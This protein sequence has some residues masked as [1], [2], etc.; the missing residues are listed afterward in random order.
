MQTKNRKSRFFLILEIATVAVAL[1]IYIA[2]FRP[3]EK[4][5]AKWNQYTER[6]QLALDKSNFSDARANFRLALELSEQ[7]RREPLDVAGVQDRLADAER[8][9]ENYG[10]A[11]SLDERAQPIFEKYQTRWEGRYADFLAKLAGTYRQVE[12]YGEAE[13]RYKQ[14][15]LLQEKIFGSEALQ[16]VPTLN[17][18]VSFYDDRNRDEIAEPLAKRSIAICKS[19]LGPKD[20]CTAYGL[21]MLS[22]VYDG[23]GKFAEAEALADE[24]LPI[25]VPCP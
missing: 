23:E 22:L 20:A 2:I 13:G 18:M 15:L 1:L 17:A 6:G 21:S 12:R 24:A 11:L 8:G 14:A 25:L 4:V 16:L 10:E 5:E 19:H 7:H 3:K 9:L